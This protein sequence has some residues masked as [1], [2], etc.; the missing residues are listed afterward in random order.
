MFS[1]LPVMIN[2]KAG[3]KMG[4]SNN[5]LNLFRIGLL[6]VVFCAFAS[7]ISALTAE[8]NVAIVD[9]KSVMAPPKLGLAISEILRTEIGQH[10]SI[11]F[12]ERGMIDQILKEQEL[13]QSGLVNLDDAVKVG[14][15]VGAEFIIIGSVVQTGAIYTINARCVNVQSSVVRVARKVN[16]PNIDK[17]PSMIEILAV[18][19]G[20]ALQA[21][22]PFVYSFE[23]GTKTTDWMRNYDDK[24]TH[25]RLSKNNATHGT[26]ALKIDLPHTEYPGIHSINFPKN[27]E[28][29]SHFSADIFYERGPDQVAL[30]IRIDD[31]NSDSYHNRFH[32][33]FI[34]SHGQN[35]IQVPIEKIRTK[36]DINSIYDVYI[37]LLEPEGP[38]TL[39]IDNIRLEQ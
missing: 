27:W 1:Y 7:P 20:E 28:V 24:N 9:F 17:I 32:S 34:L 8:L 37:F 19:I 22:K 16:A 35:Q 39:Y 21:V 11:K 5:S 25:I 13:H 26:Y 23:E 4:F 14:N 33:S 2:G 15:L 6:I 12:I 29:F 18:E 3:C 36:I 30:V 10:K 31:I 38:A